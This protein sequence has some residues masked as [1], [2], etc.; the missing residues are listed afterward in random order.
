MTCSSL[1]AMTN[2]RIQQEKYC[3]GSPHSLTKTASIFV[4]FFFSF[5]YL[6]FLF[7][8]FLFVV[9]CFVI[10][11]LPGNYCIMYCARTHVPFSPVIFTR[12]GGKTPAYYGNCFFF[13]ISSVPLALPSS[14]SSSP[15]L[16]CFEQEQ[17]HR[18]HRLQL[19]MHIS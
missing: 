3:I 2:A 7:V 4:S 11:Q 10:Y 12:L 15:S 13:F 1:F 9:F 6:F 18:L 8:C 14:S 17:Q 19:S 5:C 16:S